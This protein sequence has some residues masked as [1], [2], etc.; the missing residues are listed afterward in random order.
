[1][2]G[3]I[4][5]FPLAAFGRVVQA[6]GQGGVPGFLHGSHAGA[7]ENT[8]PDFVTYLTTNHF[9]PDSFHKFFV[10]I[11]RVK[12]NY[13]MVEGLY[14][15]P[16]AVGFS[17]AGWAVQNQVF[18]KI[19]PGRY[20]VNSIL[21]HGTGGF[22]VGTSVGEIGVFGH[23]EQVG[24]KAFV[25]GGGVDIGIVP[26]HMRAA[27]GGL[28]QFEQTVFPTPAQGLV[29]EQM[30]IAVADDDRHI[31]GFFGDRCKINFGE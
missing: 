20:V 28:C 2:G 16:G 8:F 19:G 30:R 9:G 1:M 21:S 15:L 3:G 5:Q 6:I 4:G 10:A 23:P 22:V 24:Q 17:R 29:V 18:R 13:L 14:K 31:V 11:R 26:G 27:F 25:F 7:V 12:R